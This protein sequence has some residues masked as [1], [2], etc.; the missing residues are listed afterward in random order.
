MVMGSLH[1]GGHDDACE[2]ICADGYYI[3]RIPSPPVMGNQIELIL[4]REIQ[5][6]LRANLQQGEG[7][8]DDRY[9]RSESSSCPPPLD[10]GS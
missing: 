4:S 7:A 9:R 6:P 2:P 10:G 5:N 1:D 3:G 8:C